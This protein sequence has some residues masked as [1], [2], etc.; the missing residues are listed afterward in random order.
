MSRSLAAV[1]DVTL[2]RPDATRAEVSELCAR[3][4]EVGA[5]AVCVSPT[6]LPLVELVGT[7]TKVC[8]VVGFPSGAHT[9]AIKAAE[10]TAAVV[11]GADEIDMVINLG[12]VRSGDYAT[13]AAEI[14]AVR[15]VCAETTLKV[16][17]ESAALGCRALIEVAKLAVDNGAD[18]LKTSTGFHPAGGATLAAVEVL[19]E[20]AANSGRTVGVKA[21]GGIRSY[22]DAARMLDAGAT[23]L[24]VS[25]LAVLFP[26]ETTPND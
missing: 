19:A 6:M 12:A 20:V 10:A 16:I 2:L 9:A 13:V 21:S 23:R 15:A 7:A 4:V 24:G 11:A 5:A 17:V 25:S 14:A 22:V 26:A 3:G 18:F 8:T 1:S